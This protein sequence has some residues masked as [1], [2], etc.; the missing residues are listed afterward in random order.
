MLCPYF[1]TIMYTVYNVH[2]RINNIPL[3]LYFGSLF[4]KYKNL[5]NFPSYCRQINLSSYNNDNFMYS[6]I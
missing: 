5:N 4:T 2:P 3:R 1:K 6:C